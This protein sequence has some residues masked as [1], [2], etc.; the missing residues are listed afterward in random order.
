MCCVAGR[1][2]IKR[3]TSARPT[4]TTTSRTTVTTI[5]VFAR[6]ALC[7]RLFACHARIHRLSWMPCGACKCKVQVVVPCRVGNVSFGQINN[8]PG[9]SGRSQ[10]SNALPGLSFIHLAIA[11]DSDGYFHLIALINTRL[12]A[13]LHSITR[14]SQQC[15]RKTRS[16]KT[17]PTPS[18]I[19]ST[20]IHCHLGDAL[21]AMTP[22]RDFQR[23]FRP[24]TNMAESIL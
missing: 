17:S 5:T 14:S 13:V 19:V 15:E 1:S 6:P 24:A 2:T 22:T 4:V 9:R 12:S 8:R 18:S 3:R 11:A 16:A 10:D 21:G 23:V 7:G 20:T